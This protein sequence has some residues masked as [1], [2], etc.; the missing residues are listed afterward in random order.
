MANIENYA[1]VG[2]G[3]RGLMGD[4]SDMAGLAFSYAFPTASSARD[5]KV[6]EVFH[7]WQLTRF[8][9]LTRRAVD[10]RSRQRPLSRR[11]GRVLGATPYRHLRTGTIRTQRKQTKRRA[12]H[13]GL[14]SRGETAATPHDPP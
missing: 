7:R 13:A 14:A 1:Q 5:E 12:A 11:G 8:A 9:V 6:V 10:F 2:V 4:P 3:F